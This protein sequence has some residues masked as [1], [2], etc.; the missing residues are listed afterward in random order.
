MLAGLAYAPLTARAGIGTEDTPPAA[1]VAPSMVWNEETTATDAATIGAAQTDFCGCGDD[2]REYTREPTPEVLQLFAAARD[3]DEATFNR[4]I[5]G[6]SD[7]REYAVN[8]EPLLHTVIS[9]N[10]QLGRDGDGNRVW[11]DADSAEAQ[12][13]LRAHRASLPARTR[14]LALALAHGAGVNDV[15]RFASHTPLQL[16]SAFGSPD[17]VRLLL[18]HGASATARDGSE[19]LSALEFALEPDKAQR[20]SSAIPPHLSPAER[21]EIVLA[22]LAARPRTLRPYAWIDEHM[23]REDAA[24]A[25]NKDQTPPRPSADYLIW[26]ALLEMTRGTAVLDAM[27]STGTL[28]AIDVNEAGPTPLDHAARA[29]NVEGLKWLQARLPRRMQGK[30]GYAPVQTYTFDAWAKAAAWALYPRDPKAQ[31][32]DQAEVLKALLVPDLA[33]D[34]PIQLHDESRQ[35]TLRRNV[36]GPRAGDTLTHHLAH[37][38]H[39]AGLR[40][41][42]KLG[43]PLEGTASA[44]QPGHPPL[45]T[46]VLANQATT[47]TA[48]LDLGANPLAGTDIDDSPLCQVLAVS[49]QWSN[50]YDAPQDE[51]SVASK[52]KILSAMLARLTPAQRAGLGAQTPSPMALALQRG[53]RSGAALVRQL[54]DAGVPA[55]GVNGDGLV[56]AMLVKDDPQLPIALLDHGASMAMPSYP[57]VDPDAKPHLPGSVLR[58]ALQ[59]GRAD[60]LPRLLAAGADPNQSGSDVNDLSAVEWTVLHAD[61][62]SL[63]TLLAH[64]GKLQSPD[65]AAAQPTERP[66]LLDLALASGDEAMLNRV[67]PLW[68]G[69]LSQA[70]LPDSTFFQT[71]LLTSDS[72]WTQALA[73]GLGRT[74]PT[75]APHAC[76]PPSALVERLVNGLLQDSGDFYAGWRQTRLADRLR[77]LYSLDQTARTLSPQQA[78]ALVDAAKDAQRPD[79]LSALSTV[80]LRSNPVKPAAAVPATWPAAKSGDAARQKKMVGHYYLQGVREVGSE[81]L[82]TADGRFQYML[83]YGASEEQAE[84]E[85][86]VRAGKL[87][88]RTPSLPPRSPDDAPFALQ[89]NASGDAAGTSADQVSIQVT[90]KGRPLSVRA[91]AVGC[92]V[93]QFDRGNTGSDGWQGHIKGPVCQI[94]LAHPQLN[95]G[96]AVVHDASET[97][98]RR[99]YTFTAQ[100]SAADQAPPPFNVQM[101]IAGPNLL[102]DRGGRELRYVR[103]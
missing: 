38:G 18:Q 88:F 46:A 70:C 23:A 73:Q 33:W 35:W 8:E 101:T 79:L 30:R 45:L 55:T 56:S 1:A 36:A 68:G 54:L 65:A 75:S 29:G 19:G 15:S 91:Q 58:P 89:P 96:A 98:E 74:A 11:G 69:D 57:N 7:L 49:G 77:A 62:A 5:E 71:A 14:M 28:P 20:V 26:P 3:A 4:L 34:M 40:Q 43:A 10:P 80:G 50:G 76:R 87:W 86:A 31:A 32:Q 51:A 6:I 85:W 84:G 82:L 21:S 44:G 60:L 61:H 37:K 25:V 83:V 12:K 100:P 24:D 53:D 13:A 95:Q 78:A 92:E 63:D 48:L 94:V 103:H 16:A 67:A 39:E 102:W 17:M 59:V 27:A 97:P 66:Q 42:V 2:W 93:G 52:A 64:G 99:H 9:P 81:I 22:L 72:F 90:Y 41:A 47:A